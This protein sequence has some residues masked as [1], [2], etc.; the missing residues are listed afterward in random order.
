MVKQVSLIRKYNILKNEIVILTVANLSPVKGIDLLLKSFFKLSH[1]Y[2]FIKLFIVGHK[3][4]NYG[5]MIENTAKNSS[6]KSKIHLT[7][8]V[9]EVIDFYSIADIF[10]LPTIKKGEGCPVSLLEAMS[11]GI[12]PVASNVSGIKDILDP[13]PELLFSP[14]DVDSLVEKIEN[15]IKKM[16]A[17]KRFIE[18]IFQINMI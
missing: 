2:N 1:K 14:G 5:K 18:S 17:K 16:M 12:P 3:S 13:F 11:C 9:D 4:S 6:F 7:G 15:L 8:K 10:V